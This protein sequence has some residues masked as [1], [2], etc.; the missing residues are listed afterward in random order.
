MKINQK[1]TAFSLFGSAKNI[2]TIKLNDE[3]RNTVVQ[4]LDELMTK[5]NA[6][7]EVE[8]EEKEELLELASDL[9]NRVEK[10]E[11]VPKLTLKNFLEYGANI[12]DISGLALSIVQA[13]GVIPG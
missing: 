7:Q 13:L 4:Q 6:S 3:E 5:L 1:Q 9:K 2:A 11:K 8:A 10:K 12:S